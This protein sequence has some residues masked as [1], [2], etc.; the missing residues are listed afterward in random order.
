MGACCHRAAGLNSSLVE[1]LSATRDPVFTRFRL[2]AGFVQERQLPCASVPSARVSCVGPCAPTL[3]RPPAHLRCCPAAAAM[4][5]VFHSAHPF[6]PTLRADVR[7]FEVG[8]CVLQLVLQL[9]TVGARTDKRSG[10]RLRPLSLCRCS[11][12]L[13]LLLR[14]GPSKPCSSSP[15]PK[16]V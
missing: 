5:L 16:R 2:T 1:Q 10:P 9:V 15:T 8:R 14:A 6:I 13:L 12:L 11:L 3:T 4:S 7:L